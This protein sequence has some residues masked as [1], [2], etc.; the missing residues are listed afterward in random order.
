[1]KFYLDTNIFTRLRTS[2][3]FQPLLIAVQSDLLHDHFYYSQAHLLDLK[4]DLTD[5]K[6]LDFDFIDGITKNKF[7]CKYFQQPTKLFTISSKTA[8]EYL[9]ESDSLFN[10]DFSAI[11][12]NPSI[13]ISFSQLINALSNMDCSKLDFSYLPV[14][15]KNYLENIISQKEK[16]DLIRLITNGLDFYKSIDTDNK[17]YKDIRRI[18]VNNKKSLFN[19]EKTSI[20]KNNIDELFQNSIFKNNFIDYIDSIL[21]LDNLNDDE[22]LY[23]RF[24]VAYNILNQMGLDEEP[25][26]KSMFRNTFNDSLHAY[27]AFFCDFIISND[28]SML[29]KCNF[30]FSLFGS[31]TKAINT[32]IFLNCY[33]ELSVN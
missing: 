4:N 16:P 30:I 13:Q 25:I 26:K 3:D 28:F 5:E 6:Y 8:F 14:T 21:K 18:I 7:I 33:N 24:L 17:A 9:L 10:L 19:R 11:K 22:R 20:S 31:Q 32:S 15:L 12:D 29:L 2:P 23:N 1:M 27:Y